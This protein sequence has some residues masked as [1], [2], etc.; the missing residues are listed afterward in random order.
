M[1]SGTIEK[2]LISYGDYNIYQS[3]IKQLCDE[4]INSLDFPEMV[5]KTPGFSGLL[6]YIY[7]NALSDIIEYSRGK[8]NNSFKHGIDF[9]LLDNIFYNL[10]LP[11]CYRYGLTPTILQFCVLC[12]LA[13]SHITDIKNGIYS[14]NGTKVNPLHT[15]TVKNWFSTCESALFSRAVD[16]NSIG[17]IFGLKACYQYSDQQ[18]QQVQITT[19]QTLET[20]EQIAERHK[21]AALPEKPI[22]ED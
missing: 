9:E 8:E 1:S 2:A 11:L 6:D 5:Y 17:A 10:Y 14:S 22:L 15:K 7:K 13:N 18:V 21:S 3:D 4:Y 19:S 16:A 12:K 20:P